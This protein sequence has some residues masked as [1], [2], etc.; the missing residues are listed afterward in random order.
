MTCENSSTGARTTHYYVE[1]TTC[2]TVP[3]SPVWTPIRY[4]GGNIKLTKDSLQSAE[5]NGSREVA[6]IRLGQNQTA[7]EINIELSRGSYTDLF[8]A[9]LGGTDTAGLS[10]TGVSASVDA[11]NGRFERLTGSW[12][13]DGVVI[14]DLVKFTGFTNA[15]NNG[16]FRVR[17]VGALQLVVGNSSNT[18][19]TESAATVSYVTGSKIQV[20]T[21]RRTFSI[22][23]HYADADAGAGE[24][25]ITTGCEIT[26]YS[27]DCSVNAMVT[28]S[29]SV[30][31]RDYFADTSL[32]SGSTF[33]TV[34]S[35]EVYSSVDGIITEGTSNNIIGYVTSLSFSLDNSAS[36][37][38][39]IGDDFAAFIEQG[40]ANS[41][42]SISTFFMDS[43]LL[44]KFVNEEE[45][46][47]SLVLRGNSGAMSFRFPRVIYTSGGIDL[48]G[49]GSITQTFDAQALKPTSASE[50]SVEI[51]TLA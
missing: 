51:R 32:P 50:T 42:L 19:V 44:S 35:N 8:E 9:A 33:N 2:N 27:I 20:G 21:N 43:T 12:V 41:T 49:E 47:V 46:A 26:G 15:A 34:N 7:G 31:G 25:H 16:Y 45:T 18:L 17:N 10:I 29:F 6:D 1:E 14:G 11:T 24:Y 38:Y 48:S 40:R 37:Q 36:A 30:I 28:G 5:L 23:T 39:A 22:L 4:T 3:T 13:T